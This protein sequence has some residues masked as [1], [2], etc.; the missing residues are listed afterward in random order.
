MQAYALVE[1]LKELGHDVEIIDY[2]PEYL[3]HYKLIGVNNPIYDKPILREMYTLAKLPGRVREKY[4]QRKKAFDRF[5]KQYLPL[6][7]R[8]YASWEE[9]KDNP[10][11]ADVIFAGSDQIWNTFFSNGRDP[12]FYLQFVPNGC[13]RASYAASFATDEI[14]EEW[15]TNVAKWLSE[16]DFISVRETTGVNIVQELGIDKV[17]QQVLDPVFLLGRKQ[18]NALASDNALKR[19]YVL[20]YDF[21]NC[22]EIADFAK[23]IAKIK[24]CNVYSVLKNPFISK[25]FESADPKMFITLMKNAEVVISNSF[26]ATAFSLIFEKEFWVFSRQEGINTRMQDLLEL[27]NLSGRLVSNS[28]SIEL[29]EKEID[30]ERVRA[31]LQHA[32]KRSK[33]YIN[34]VLWYEENSICH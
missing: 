20:V 26:H 17:V 1:Y 7:A 23:R 15:K 14:K 9:L 19:P 6:T 30:Y 12:A 34:Q 28:G 11:E 25:N 24:R 21:D 22:K 5:T 3:R 4:G 8:H 13:I 27:V 16:M 32:I 31:C 10:P 2:V 33:D 29:T 18:W